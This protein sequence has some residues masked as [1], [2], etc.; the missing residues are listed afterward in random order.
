MVRTTGHVGRTFGVQKCPSSFL[1][2]GAPSFCQLWWF[3]SVANEQTETTLLLKLHDLFAQGGLRDPESLSGSREI[4]LICQNHSCIE[5][6]K[7]S[8]RDSIASTAAD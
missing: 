1:N 8:T 6:T 7:F 5:M 2:E 3:F 4:Q